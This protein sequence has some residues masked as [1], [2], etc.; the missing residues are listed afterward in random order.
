MF[1]TEL[2]VARTYRWDHSKESKYIHDRK[3]CSFPYTGSLCSQTDI[4][5]NKQTWGTWHKWV[6]N[7]HNYAHSYFAFSH[8]N[9]SLF[10]SLRFSLGN[11]REIVNAHAQ[12]YA[13]LVFRIYS[14]KQE[15]SLVPKIQSWQPKRNCKRFRGGINNNKMTKKITSMILEWRIEIELQQKHFLSS[16]AKDRWFSPVILGFL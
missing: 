4:S 3:C 7:A 6:A 8:F 9:K 13:L 5:I 15:A 16:V 11:S 14:L 1:Q 12:N 2:S 10:L